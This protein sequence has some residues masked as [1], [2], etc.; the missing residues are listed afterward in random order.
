MAV[1]VNSPFDVVGYDV[2]GDQ[3]RKFEDEGGEVRDSPR[4]VA[5]AADVVFLSLPSEEAVRS[6]TI[7]SEGLVEALDPDDVLVNTSTVGPALTDSVATACAEADV[8]FLDAP[9]HGGP[10]KAD[11]GTLVFL[12]GGPTDVLESVRPVFATMAET[13]H[14]VADH[15]AETAIKLASNYM[16][17]VQQLALCESLA[18][19]RAAGIDDETF[20]ETIP[21]TAGDCYALN[22]NVAQFVIPDQFEPEAQQS[23]VR[24]DL[25][26]AE[27]MATIFNVPLLS[28]G[29]SHIYRYAEN[30]GLADEDTASL[31]KLFEFE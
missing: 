14:L 8:G 26:L 12:V 31:I 4:A 22:R 15:G 10:R 5:A 29:V 11:G 25:E 1:E 28:G 27:Q 19:A 2:V 13:I 16:F 20:A 23:I 21:D 30:V 9:V 24:K 6:V 7:G 3:R 17:G 18:M